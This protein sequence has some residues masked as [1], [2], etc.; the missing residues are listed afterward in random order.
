VRVQY[1][2]PPFPADVV[3]SVAREFM[4]SPDQIGGVLVGRGPMTLA[5]AQRA[6]ASILG[7]DEL[8]VCAALTS[9]LRCMR[10]G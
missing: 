1:N 10:R 9:E 4:L 2:P 5:A 7:R 6:A 3:D 8:A